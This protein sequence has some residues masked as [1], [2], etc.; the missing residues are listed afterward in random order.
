MLKPATVVDLR[1]YAILS[2]T[3][4]SPHVLTFYFLL[5]SFLFIQIRCDGK[6]P[7]CSQCASVGFEC[8]ISDKLSRRA[9]PRGY[10]ESLEDRVRQLES[11]NHKLLNLLDIKDEQM[12]L[13][14]KVDAVHDSIKPRPAPASDSPSN[15]N[16]NSIN[17]NNNSPGSINASSSPNKPETPD[18]YIVSSPDRISASKNFMG[19]STGSIFV[20][21]FVEKLRNKNVAVVPLVEKLFETLE[22]LQPSATNSNNSTNNNNNMYNNSTNNNTT[23]NNSNNNSQ[24]YTS[25]MVDYLPTPASI[26]TP[27]SINTPG[28]SESPEK[29]SFGFGIPNRLSSDKLTTIYFNEWNSM[30]NIIDQAAFLDEYQLLM[31]ELSTGEAGGL[32]D[33]KKDKDNIFFVTILLVLALGS[34]ASK[35]KTSATM[36]SESIKLDQDWKN[37]FTPQL[38]TKPA[39]STLRA[40]L[41][42]LLYSLHTGNTEDIWHYRMMTVNMAQRLGLHRKVTDSAIVGE[43]DCRNR[44][45]W[46][47]Y[48]LDCFAAAQ[49]GAPRLFNDVNI[50]CPLP[51]KGFN[52]PCELSVYQFSA[53]LAK[54]IETLYTSKVKSH[55]YKTV[56]MLEDH[57]ESWKRELPTE[58]KFEFADGA[59]VAQSSSPVHQKSPLFFM[60]YHYA[61]ILL[62]LPALCSPPDNN[63]KR[64]L[65]TVSVIQ[66]AKLLLELLNYLK[67]RNVTSTLPLNTYKASVFFGSLVLYG[68]VDYSKSGA[69]LTEVRK[70]LSV[71]LT[72]LHSDLIVRKPGVITQES[73]FIFE[74][75]CEILSSLNNNPVASLTT[76]TGVVASGTNNLRSTED[77]KK[78]K[79]GKKDAAKGQAEIKEQVSPPAVSQTEDREA[80]RYSAINDLLYL[81]TIASQKRKQQQEKQTIQSQVS[82]SSTVHSQTQHQTLTQPQTQAQPQTIPIP[83]ALSVT[84]VTRKI[85]SPLSQP[86]LPQHQG[87]SM[88]SVSPP[89]IPKIYDAERKPTGLACHNNSSSNLVHHVSPPHSAIGPVPPGP[90]RD[91]H[92][93]AHG[94]SSNFRLH[95]DNTNTKSNSPSI[96]AHNSNESHKLHHNSSGGVHASP[97]STIEQPMHFENYHN[98]PILLQKLFRDTK[99]MI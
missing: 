53:C 11:E 31:T 90:T 45:L 59:P 12:E 43:E 76:T 82:A 97:S 75:I 88:Y 69:L 66:S 77:K 87:H 14:A 73:F 81:N 19:A 78:R 30:Y 44:L 28:H 60:F 40:L 32:Y 52:E 13:L 2:S 67:A 23:H 36:V 22:C 55:P 7:H 95:H 17:K 64:G 93:A 6:R 98:D 8:K 29:L 18:V 33:M 71:T 21:A 9:F 56:V 41:L 72:Q 34:L 24:P 54:I 86:N 46:T 50:E 74:E 62:H 26:S 85:G 38:Q 20:T 25:P 47:T 94:V 58:L 35:D 15:P 83:R 68:A 57:L 27:A 3:K 42:A 91:E 16:T 4:L 63:T 80:L 79:G 65:S 89:S 10:T 99:D 37:A 51:T 39:Y 5:F 96:S 84:A 49:I 61:R 92:L 48:S 1:R 70:T